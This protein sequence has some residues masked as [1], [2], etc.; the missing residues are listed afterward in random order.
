MPSLDELFEQTIGKS[1]QESLD[2][3][4]NS[5]VGGQ[6]TPQS[7]PQSPIEAP[8]QPIAEAPRVTPRVSDTVPEDLTDE[9]DFPKPGDTSA[10]EA[11]AS[12]DR[13]FGFLPT[14]SE[15]DDFNR[16]LV[17]G[18]KNFGRKVGLFITDVA[19]SLGMAGTREGQQE[20]R[21]ELK[22]I[23]AEE[24]AAV[25]N[26]GVFNVAKTISGLVPEIA[27]GGGGA[28]A[29]ARIAGK[30]GIRGALRV[31]SGD[32]AAGAATGA[33][34]ETGGEAGE[35]GTNAVI[36]AALSGGL[37][38]LFRGAGTL[39]RGGKQAAKTAAEIQRQVPKELA[40]AVPLSVGQKSGRPLINRFEQFSRAIPGVGT[41]RFFNK[42][43]K[44]LQASID[45]F[46]DSITPKTISKE[47]LSETGAA[48]T[49]S[50]TRN[51][52]RIDNIERSM[53]NRVRTLTK[54]AKIKPAKAIAYIDEKVKE[55][56]EL[57]GPNV[58]KDP[59]LAKQFESEIKFREMLKAY[60]GF[61]DV[62]FKQLHALRQKIDNDIFKLTHGA[63]PSKF[64]KR[65]L[66]GLR[67]SMEDDLETL[68]ANA[69][70]KAGR[71]YQKAKEFYI[72]HKLPF[73]DPL[74]RKAES[75]DRFDADRIM[76][77]FLRP[78]R[79]ELAKQLV[80]NLDRQGK[81][82]LQFGIVQRAYKKA[83]DPSTGEL[84]L[85][86]FSR[87]MTKLG[88]T[89]GV[90]LKPQTK[91]MSDGLIKLTQAILKEERTQ[92][93]AGTA[94]GSASI[95]GGGLGVVT[96]NLGTTLGVGSTLFMLSKLLTSK[97]G[98]KLLIRSAN[99]SPKSQMF[100]EITRRLSQVSLIDETLG[101]DE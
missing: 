77:T 43:S 85:K 19:A 22:R 84:A 54:G 14:E 61:D 76:D 40:E 78:N 89:L 74:L 9:G 36:G 65:V 16:G 8:Q 48:L 75:L 86:K 6:S 101:E 47:S 26:Q 3:I 73:A 20:R 38:S 62:D 96:G 7:A 21:E 39:I 95:V 24:E 52:S 91:K 88:E 5:T 66:S 90:V 12:E 23:R 67:K 68:A 42:Q 53:Y 56:D 82:A 57:L 87:E 33:I 1:K 59:K 79:P 70:P 2:S 69:N 31:L 11:A 100:R 58:L 13:P 17:A 44:Q 98:Q 10:G 49:N 45:D 71:A 80:R 41:G 37:G 83:I 64:E 81:E 25:K 32:V 93:L 35:R 55:L 27:L 97:V 92:S 30:A 72:K 28:A 18:T 63:N 50:L 4:F 94:I 51:L 99:L 29:G 46:V 34:Q 60:K 15:L